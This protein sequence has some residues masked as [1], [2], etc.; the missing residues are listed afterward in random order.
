MGDVQSIEVP[1]LVGLDLQTAQERPRGLGFRTQSVDATGRG[2]VQVID[3][4]CQVVRQQP[5]AG[6]GGQRLQR[7]VLHVQLFGE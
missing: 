4:N 6:D 1:N 2:R 3:E 7:V 5:S